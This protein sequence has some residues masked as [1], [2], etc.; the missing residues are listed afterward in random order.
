MTD[1]E[2]SAAKERSPNY[3]ALGLP[4]AIDN[5]RK[6]WQHA[7]RTPVEADTAARAMG[8]NSL[9]GPARTA[10]GALRQYGLIESGQG[11][12]TVSGLAVNILVHPEG[13]A[14]WIEAVTTAAANPALFREIAETH[15]NT[16]DAVL[17]AY[18]YS[19]KK[20][21]MDGAK[22]FIR[23]Y[24]ET[25]ALANRV[26]GG[27]NEAV[28]EPGPIGV[29]D[30]NKPQMSQQPQ[31]VVDQSVAKIAALLGDGIKAE[32]L[33]YGGEPGPDHISRLE[34]VLHAN[35]IALGGTPKTND[36]G[37]SA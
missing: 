10:I 7:K 31:V 27:Y 35:Y 25:T 13:S 12:V 32:V 8:Y 1:T 2:Q 3:P 29:P 11:A 34:A 21:S 18:L 5:V 37:S 6:L 24:R 26:G 30:R 16:S 22:R 36:R 23:S 33:F 20:F 9:S 28:T 17:S 15:A 4:T 14:D 19:K